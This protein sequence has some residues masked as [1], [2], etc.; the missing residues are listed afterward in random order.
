MPLRAFLLLGRAPCCDVM[1]RARVMGHNA[2]AGIFAFRTFSWERVEN[3]VFSVT[4]PLRAFLLLG[5]NIGGMEAHRK[6]VT[7][8]LRAF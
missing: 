5:Q 6:F 4:M 1:A 3:R 2:L 8:P 7:M